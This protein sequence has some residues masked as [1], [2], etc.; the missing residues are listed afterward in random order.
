MKLT[1]AAAVIAAALMSTAFLAAP[2]ATAQSAKATAGDLEVVSV[3][4]AGSG[5]PAGTASAALLGATSFQVVYDS[6]AVDLDQGTNSVTKEKFCQLLVALKVPAGRQILVT[7]AT[8]RGFLTVGA[9]TTAK[10]RTLYYFANAPASDDQSQVFTL[11]DTPKPE[12]DWAR[13][14]LAFNQTWSPCG[15]TIYFNAKG[16]LTLGSTGRHGVSHLTMDSNNST[17]YDYSERSC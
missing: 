6:F 14:S 17:V 10:L 9:G 15:G 2:S 7:Q 12:S 16:R 3:S 11:A 4:P 13:T 8:Y 1:K 5:C